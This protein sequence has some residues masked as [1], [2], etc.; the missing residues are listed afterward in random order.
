MLPVKTAIPS[1]WQWVEDAI[2]IN[3]EK[4]LIIE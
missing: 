1:L 3:I 4:G 2:V